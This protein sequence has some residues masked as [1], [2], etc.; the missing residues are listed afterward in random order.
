ML[1]PECQNLIQTAIN[2]GRSTPLPDNPQIR[3]TFLEDETISTLLSGLNEG[4]DYALDISHWRDR[5]HGVAG[6]NAIVY[7]VQPVSF[8]AKYWTAISPCSG[9]SVE[10]YVPPGTPCLEEPYEWD[11]RE[12][13][14]QDIYTLAASIDPD[15]RRVFHLRDAYVSSEKYCE[16]IKT[17]AIPEFCGP[18][19]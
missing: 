13:S 4:T 9:L 14:I 15:S 7:F 11:Q 8:D 3:T 1:S 12:R 19:D 10:G 6:G 5:V 16:V 2:E 18:S 17:M